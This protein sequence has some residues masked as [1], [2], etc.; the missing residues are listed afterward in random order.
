[1]PM[2]F[3]QRALVLSHGLQI[4]IR[5]LVQSH[6]LWIQICMDFPAG[7]QLVLVGFNPFISHSP[8]VHHQMT[9]WM[10]VQCNL[11]CAPVYTTL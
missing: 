9:R 6:S 11:I 10:S 2:S 5:K 3:L 4:Y 1:M 8:V 7:N